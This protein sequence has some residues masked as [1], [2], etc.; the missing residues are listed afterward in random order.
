MELTYFRISGVER[1]DYP[2]KKRL[3]VH[4]K[5]PNCYKHKES[6]MSSLAR[7]WIKSLLFAPNAS[8]LKRLTKRFLA[9]AMKNKMQV[10]SSRH[11]TRQDFGSMP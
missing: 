5:R 7:R 10:K 6:L 3:M 11:T 8:P 2:F 1:A 9:I 4:L